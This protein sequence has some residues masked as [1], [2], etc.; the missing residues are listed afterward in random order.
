MKLS[1]HIT[2][3]ALIALCFVGSAAAHDEAT[4]NNDAR[5]GS[6]STP[7]G[8]CTGLSIE[9]C[10]YYEGT[11]SIG[12]DACSGGCGSGRDSIAESWTSGR[13]ASSDP[14]NAIRIGPVN[15]T[16][17]DAVITAYQKQLARH[18]ATAATL[19][20]DNADLLSTS[21]LVEVESLQRSLRNAYSSTGGQLPLNEPPFSRHSP[22]FRG[23]VAALVDQS[24]KTSAQ[25]ESMVTF[26]C[27]EANAT[28]SY[29][30]AMMG[31]VYAAWFQSMD[32]I[33]EG[34]E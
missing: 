12:S 16:Q 15:H 10:N 1:K 17:S 20:E 5:M 26:N 25:I 11:T 8:N 2:I 14:S 23:Y 34:G 13:G 19:I 21:C 29:K 7:T 3:A 32:N 28:T 27:Q 33:L 30:G 18:A 22:E 4:A 24:R 31:P 6:N 9:G